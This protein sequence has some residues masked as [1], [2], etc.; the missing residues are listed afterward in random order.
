MIRWPKKPSTVT[1]EPSAA[2]EREEDRRHREER[3]TADLIEGLC[4][5]MLPKLKGRQAA[6]L[7]TFVASHEADAASYRFSCKKH[8]DFLSVFV[9]RGEADLATTIN[10]RDCK[11][12][13]MV[14]G[15][16]PDRAGIVNFHLHLNNGNGG[17]VTF[18]GMGFSPASKGCFYQVW[19]HEPAPPSKLPMLELSESQRDDSAMHGFYSYTPRT[20]LKNAARPARD[21]LVIFR[22]VGTLYCPHGLGEGAL[23]KV[24][25]T[26]GR[27]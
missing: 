17:Y 11:E 24:L 13:K 18:P 10:L 6:R 14:P 3:E 27:K 19:P 23:A 5:S 25:T 15:G 8:G 22:G 1:V 9:T 4:S 7:K 26:L 20:A 21:D 2:P 12:I 16:A